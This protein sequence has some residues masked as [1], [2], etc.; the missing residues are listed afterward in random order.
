VLTG[1]RRRLRQFSTVGEA[2]EGD[3]AWLIG[4]GALY[5][6]RDDIGSDINDAETFTWTLDT[7]IKHG[8][9]GFYGALFASNSDPAVGTSSDRIGAVG[10][11]SA[12]IGER[13]D[14]FARY[15]WA[16]A[17]DS[18]SAGSRDEL[19]VLTVGG[20]YYM[21][22]HALKLTADLGYAFNGVADFWAAGG[23]GYLTDARG[24]RGQVVVR[25][26]VQVVF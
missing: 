15:E 1:D 6:D 11:A 17:D 4:G 21:I 24:E 19:S 10:Q 26:Q 7:L 13:H 20:N 5:I 12:R 25:M 8:R 14:V 22:E 18:V 2:G 16:D 9:Y 23:S 3:F